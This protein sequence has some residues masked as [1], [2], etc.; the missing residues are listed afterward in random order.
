M[1]VNKAINE[2]IKDVG[3]G[4]KSWSLPKRY[5]I[6]RIVNENKNSFFAELSGF[7]HKSNHGTNP[8]LLNVNR[9]QEIYH[10]V[11]PINP[12]TPR[13]KDSE[14]QGQENEIFM[15]IVLI[16]SVKPKKK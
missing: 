15:K 8:R 11:N 13:V 5:D 3:A 4:K 14:S 9:Y 10:I 2:K 6:I 12:M 1:K 16:K 7:C